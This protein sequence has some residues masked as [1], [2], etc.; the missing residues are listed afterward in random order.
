MEPHIDS[1][2]QVE[3]DLNRT[4]PTNP[5]FKENQKGFKRLR[6]VLRA[7]SC[8][9]KQ[10]NYVQG[11]NFIAGQL[12]M[13]CSAPLAF[14]LFVELI[15]GC[16]VRDIYQYDLP[17]LIKHSYIIRLLIM[18]HLPDLH[19]QLNFYEIRPEQYASSFIFSIF[20]NV[21]PEHKTDISKAFFTLFF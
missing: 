17:G 16:E 18:K 8:Y 19:R 5:Y 1:A 4:F 13:H 20:M 2:I 11:M 3:K 10:V 15:E 14:W 6:K 9:D 12:L 7:F 21:L